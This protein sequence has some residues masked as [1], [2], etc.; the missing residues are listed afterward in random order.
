[1]ASVMLWVTTSLVIIFTQKI[2]SAS[3][4]EPALLINTDKNPETG[5]TPPTP[6]PKQSPIPN[7]KQPNVVKQE[8]Q[9]SEAIARKL[10]FVK[11]DRLYLG[12]GNQRRRKIISR[13]KTTL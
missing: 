6:T 8:T 2:I 5:K 13:S 4:Q 11:A 9:T 12:G 7:Q 3:A 1:M 10:K